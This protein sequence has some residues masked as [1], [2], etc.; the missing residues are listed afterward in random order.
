MSFFFTP[1]P[2]PRFFSLAHF[3]ASFT[4][5][6][7]QGI[8]KNRQRRENDALLLLLLLLLLLMVPFDAE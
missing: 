4:S 8:K 2:S 6:W 5:N 7:H 1:F 3:F